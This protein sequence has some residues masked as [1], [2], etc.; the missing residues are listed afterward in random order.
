MRILN[1]RTVLVCWK[2][3]FTVSAVA[4]IEHVCLILIQIIVIYFV[5]LV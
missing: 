1:L 3:S 2:F 5:Y 4:V